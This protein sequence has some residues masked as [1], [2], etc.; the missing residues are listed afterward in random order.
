[1]PSPTYSLKSNELLY[2]NINSPQTDISTSLRRRL[3]PATPNTTLEVSW[4]IR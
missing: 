4:E 1:M 3:L 2:L